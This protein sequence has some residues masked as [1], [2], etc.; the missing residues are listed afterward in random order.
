MINMEENG[1]VCLEGRK[2]GGWS[3]HG[4]YGREWTGVPGGEEGGR[5]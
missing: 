3:A 5:G 1:L 2:V 4:K